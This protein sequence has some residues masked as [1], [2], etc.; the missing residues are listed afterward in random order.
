MF[1]LGLPNDNRNRLTAPHV[2]H[3]LAFAEH[4][5]SLSHCLVQG[6]RCHFDGMLAATE[7][8]AGHPTAAKVHI[9]AW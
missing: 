8:D 3:P 4:S 9:G 5:K 1:N 6:I 7:I 2:I